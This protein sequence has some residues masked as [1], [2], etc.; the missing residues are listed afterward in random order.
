ML[1][2]YFIRQK[3]ETQKE[4][5]LPC[6]LDW[7]EVTVGK[8]LI[9]FSADKKVSYILKDDLFVLVDGYVLTEEKTDGKD[10]AAEVYNLFK[11]YRHD[12]LKHVSGKYSIVICDGSQ[13]VLSLICDRFSEKKTCYSVNGDM[14]AFG[15]KTLLVAKLSEHEN[16]SP[17]ALGMY[18]AYNYI[19]APYTIFAEVYKVCPGRYML[20]GDGE[21]KEKVYWNPSLVK[22]ED[23]ISEKTPESMVSEAI[24]NSL[25]QK[26]DALSIKKPAL[27]LS[28][29]LDSSVLC[30]IMSE[31]GMDVTAYSAKFLD[32]GEKQD[33]SSTAKTIADHYGVPHKIVAINAEELK[34]RVVVLL[35]E[36]DEPMANRTYSISSI[37]MEH[38]KEE[39]DA[40]VTGDG[41]DE[42]FFGYPQ[43]Q[44]LSQAQSLY[45]VLNPVSK[46]VPDKVLKHVLPGKA[47]SV[48]YNSKHF[49]PAQL[50]SYNS[51]QVAIKAVIGCPEDL[52]YTIP[53]SLVNEKWYLKKNYIDLYFG[54][55]AAIRKWNDNAEGYGLI[56]FS[57]IL[58][59]SVLAVSKSLS[60]KML[61]D[62]N[63]NKIVLRN[64][65]NRDIPEVS[66]LPKHGFDVPVK[67]WLKDAFKEK[68]E[69]FVSQ[70]YIEKQGLFDPQVI[71]DIYSHF[72]KDEVDYTN[73]ADTFI[74]D[75]YAFQ[76]WYSSFRGIV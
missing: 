30:K 22:A 35:Q 43:Y 55:Q 25:N 67:C 73:N 38:A 24:T 1:I 19:C 17:R 40:I 29:G 8:S 45:K 53:S 32:G 26:M 71:S 31:S 50:F 10:Y 54:T 16:I 68:L 39:C 48:L 65:I 3:L 14:V 9:I 28:G 63:H 12:F 47:N 72:K 62:K 23:I 52:N 69:Y 70:D 51:V 11:K 33:E 5:N 37:L 21:P 41:G 49:P 56:H 34:D 7:K 76:C 59:E 4:Y 66:K 75:Y 64:I 46:V 60:T 58:N 57:P 42:L 20:I 18:F 61:F 44:R 13:G 2:G 27:F 36:S 6:E 15:S 74:W